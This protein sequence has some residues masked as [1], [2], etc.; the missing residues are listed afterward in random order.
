MCA[1]ITDKAIHTR[2]KAKATFTPLALPNLREEDTNNQQG[3][4][5]SP[6]ATADTAAVGPTSKTAPPTETETNMK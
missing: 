5:K 6:P 1:V 2:N 3:T 4:P